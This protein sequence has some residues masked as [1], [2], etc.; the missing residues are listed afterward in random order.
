MSLG[1][2]FTPESWISQIIL[3]ENNQDV[4]NTIRAN[5]QSPD[6]QAAANNLLYVVDLSIESTLFPN[7]G[8]NL[9]DIPDSVLERV[10]FPPN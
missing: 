2:Y 9:Q 8:L 10:L 5:L 4:I 3:E 7:D 1:S 6:I